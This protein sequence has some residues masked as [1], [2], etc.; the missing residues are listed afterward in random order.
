MF[1]DVGM[2][3]G[4]YKCKVLTRQQG[5]IKHSDEWKLPDSELMKEIDTAGYKYLDILQ[6]NQIK[7]RA[8]KKIWKYL[9]RVKKLVNSKLYSKNMIDRTITW[10]VGVIWHRAGTIDLTIQ[11]SK[12][13]DRRTHKIMTP[14]GALHPP[15]NVER[16]YL[17]KVRR[18]K[19]T[20]QHGKMCSSKH[21]KTECIH[22]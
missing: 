5:R 15:S 8:I 16:L 22:K 3:L 14:N 6:D 18:W 21:E 10:T 4:I 12:K 13:I 19:R 2:K 11:D 9:R 20:V 17:K 7:H 1:Q